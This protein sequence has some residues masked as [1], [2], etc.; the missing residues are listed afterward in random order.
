LLAAGAA[1]GCSSGDAAIGAAAGAGRTTS[2][3]PPVSAASESL[4]IPGDSARTGALA[5][6][7]SSLPARPSALRTLLVSCSLVNGLPM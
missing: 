4:A 2:A 1:A 3:L 5:A 7:A 6:S